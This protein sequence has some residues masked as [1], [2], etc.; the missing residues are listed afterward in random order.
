MRRIKRHPVRDRL[1]NRN[2]TLRHQAQCFFRVERVLM[3]GAGVVEE[4]D[5]P[6]DRHANLLVG[7]DVCSDALAAPMRYARLDRRV[8]QGRRLDMPFR[9]ALGRP[10]IDGVPLMPVGHEVCEPGGIRTHD[11]GIKSPLLYH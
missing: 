10:P 11:K 5:A 9:L 4:I 6:F 2:L 7:V 3:T 1:R 8:S